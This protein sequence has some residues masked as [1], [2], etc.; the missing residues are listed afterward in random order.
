MKISID[1]GDG[2]SCRPWGY[3]CSVYRRLFVVGSGFRIY[4]TV[5]ESIRKTPQKPLLL[6]GS[7]LNVVMKII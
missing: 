2:Y 4:F 6:W 7:V 3:L 1:D 5:G